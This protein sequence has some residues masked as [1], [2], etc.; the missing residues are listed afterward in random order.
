MSQQINLYDPKLLRKREL[1]TATNVAAA[2][3]ALVLLLGIGGGIARSRLGTLESE[4]QGLSPQAMV[5]KAQRDALSAQLASMKPDPQIEAELA[6]ARAQFDLRTR[7]LSELKKGLGTE[8]GGFAEYLRGLARQTPTGL[9][10][11][12]FSIADSGGTVEI[13]GRMLDPALLAEYVRRLNNEP[14]F[15]GHEFS[16]LKVAAGK[17]DD[18]PAT[19]PP[20]QPQPGIPGLPAGLPGLPSKLPTP[21]PAT[22]PS[23]APAAAPP[24]PFY[25]FTLSPSVART[26]APAGSADAGRSSGAP[27]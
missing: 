27:R 9:W 13:R 8:S 5:L 4:S 17:L 7:Q 24:A 10:L 11:T 18:T 26:A 15:K 19:T 6:T 3:G 22:A 16:A 12:G 14:V 21:A 2:A 20:A 25:E 1:L 23:P